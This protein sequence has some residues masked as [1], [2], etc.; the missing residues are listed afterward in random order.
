MQYQVDMC[1]EGRSDAVPGRPAQVCKFNKK[2]WEQLIPYFPLVRHRPYRKRRVQQFFYCCE[3]FLC[4]GKVFTDPLHSNIDIRTQAYGRH[5]WSALLTWAQVHDIHTKFHKVWF[6]H[7][8]A[9]GRGY[10]DTQ[11]GR[12]SHT[13]T[14]G[15]YTKMIVLRRVRT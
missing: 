2:S 12:G 3:C 8:K 6:R 5:L 10:T 4:R 14:V 7:S 9:D 13:A 1:T 11:T 15:K